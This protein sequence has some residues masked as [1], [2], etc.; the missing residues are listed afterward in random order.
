MDNKTPPSAQPEGTAAP[1]TA[2]KLALR[3][4]LLARRLAMP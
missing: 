1:L 3:K 4:E 2:Q